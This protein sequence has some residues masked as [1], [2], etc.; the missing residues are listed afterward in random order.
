MRPL[1]ARPLLA[2][3]PPA[4][5]TTT[6]SVVIAGGV[7]DDGGGGSSDEEGSNEGGAGGNA[8]LPLGHRRAVRQTDQTYDVDEMPCSE[9]AIAHVRDEIARLEPPRLV[10]ALSPREKLPWRT[11]FDARRALVH[12]AARERALFVYGVERE[13]IDRVYDRLV[14]RSKCMHE[15]RS[16][17]SLRDYTLANSQVEITDGAPANARSTL[18]AL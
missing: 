13:A 7:G 2:P 5:G 14:N 10:R 6:L 11:R 9:A 4:G 3:A 8:L 1:L 12:P 17:R 16:A 18:T 15:R